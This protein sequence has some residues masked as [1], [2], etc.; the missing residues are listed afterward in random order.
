MVNLLAK[1]N[2][3][4]NFSMIREIRRRLFFFERQK[5]NNRNRSPP[6]CFF[7]TR[8]VMEIVHVT[9]GFPKCPVYRF[10]LRKDQLAGFR[11]GKQDFELQIPRGSTVSRIK[12]EEVID[13]GEY[14]CLPFFEMVADQ[15]GGETALRADLL[16]RHDIRIRSHPVSNEGATVNERK[17]FSEF[18]VETGPAVCQYS[19]GDTVHNVLYTPDNGNHPSFV[20]YRDGMMGTFY[21]MELSQEMIEHHSTRQG[22][23]QKPGDYIR[24][25]LTPIVYREAMRGGRFRCMGDDSTDS[26]LILRYPVGG[27]DACSVMSI[28]SNAYHR[29]WETLILPH[30]DPKSVEVLYVYGDEPTRCVLDY[31]SVETFTSWKTALIPSV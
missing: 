4:F 20:R 31:P 16:E 22:I 26:R 9:D 5:H 14:I 11:E 10:L 23:L 17:D 27:E 6:F 12:A 7:F 13:C 29:Y 19:Q 28:H 1:G 25:W 21:T 8:K 3:F 2:V 24:V 15:N 30:G 18:Y